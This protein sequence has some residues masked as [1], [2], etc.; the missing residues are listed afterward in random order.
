MSGGVCLACV[1]GYAVG[2]D[3]FCYKTV[4]FCKA[5]SMDSKCIECSLGYYLDKSTSDAVCREQ[6]FGCNYIDGKCVSCRAPFNYVPETQSCEIDGC[7]TYFLGGC[8]QCSANYDLRYNSCKLPNCLISHKGH[9]AQCDPDYI[10]KSDGSCVN[11]DEF[12]WN[13]DSNGVCTQCAPNYYMSKLKNKCQPREPGCLYNDKDRCYDCEKPFY[14]DGVRCEIYGCMKLSPKGCD[15]CMYPMYVVKET[16]LCSVVNCDRMDGAKCA[17]CKPGFVIASDGSCKNQDPNCLVTN[18]IGCKKCVKGY[19]LDG[20]GYCQYTDEHCWDFSPQGS[21]T[22]CDRLYFLNRYNKCEIKDNNCAAYS[23][24][25]C[26]ECKSYFYNFQGLCYPNAK[27]CILQKN[28]RVCEK[29]ESGYVLGQGVCTPQ[30]TKLDWNSVD[31]DFWGG[32][33]DD[34]VKTSKEV[35]TIG[36]TNKYN[37]DGAIS[38]GKAKILY[39]SIVTGRTCFQVDDN[40]N[41]DGWTPSSSNNEFLGIVLQSRQVFYALD[42]KFIQGSTLTKFAVERSDDGK[43]FIRVS[44]FVVSQKAA[45]TVETYY[46]TAVEALAMRIVV[47]QGVPNIKFEFYYSNGQAVYPTENSTYIQDQT[48]LAVIDSLKGQVFETTSSCVDK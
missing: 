7:L 46:F 32:D 21:C 24:G 40:V 17:I 44:E 42:I 45:G 28:V 39:S 12:C 9:C 23:G 48:G 19:R 2:R 8:S 34:K 37:L 6:K 47:L 33:S 4:P 43:N 3:G 36:K 14:F 15:T 31:M 29:C 22:N 11:K 18:E 26:I 38:K 20:N 25:K 27:G 30:I 1:D 10:M 16:G 5:Y 13:Y 41:F 35:F